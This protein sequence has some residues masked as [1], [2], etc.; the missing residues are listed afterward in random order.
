[1]QVRT[2]LSESLKGVV[3]QVLCKK[4]GGGRVAAHEILLVTPA[5]SNL[6]REGKTYQIPSI[7]QTSKRIGMITMNDTLYDLVEKKIIEP[8]E[9]YM[10]S[11]DK[12][13]FLTKLREQ[14]FDTSHAETDPLAAPANASQPGGAAG[15]KP[16]GAPV[17]R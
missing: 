4:I 8:K 6:I 5:I 9:A 16:G 1:E 12:G 2:M 7:M 14:G 11:V 15:G 10:R 13:S 3:S 17:R